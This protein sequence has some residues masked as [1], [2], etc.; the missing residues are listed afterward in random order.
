MNTG[1]ESDIS[2]IILAGGEGRRVNGQDKGLVLYQ[3]KPLIEHVIDRIRPQVD[4]IV[5]SAN[6]N[7]ATYRRYADNVISDD[8]ENYMGPLAGINACLPHCRHP[9]ALIVACD[10]PRLPDDLVNRLQSAM[11]HAE[12]RVDVCIA[13]VDKRHQL[14]LLMRTDLQAG[15]AQRLTNNQ[16]KLIEWV[17]SQHYSTVSFDDS[18]QAFANLNTLEQL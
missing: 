12:E 7:L 18:T 4:D 15:I 9:L 8:R 10:L 6:R 13:T 2:C 14:T 11:K 16:L 1:S 17:E 5:I 3:D